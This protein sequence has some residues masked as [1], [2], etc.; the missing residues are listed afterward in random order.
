MNW[1]TFLGILT[2][3]NLFYLYRLFQRMNFYEE[4]FMKLGEQMM[5][6]ALYIEKMEDKND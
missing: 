5:K 6:M 2:G 3:A 1:L 4:A